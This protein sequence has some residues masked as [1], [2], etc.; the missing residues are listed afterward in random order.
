MERVDPTTAGLSPER[1]KMMDAAMQA[2]VD[3]GQLAGV[4]TVLVRHGKVAHW[5]M[6]GQRDLRQG[7]PVEEDTL[8]RI[9]SMTKPVTS[10]AVLMLLEEGCLQL[11]TPIAEYIPELKHMNVLIGQNDGVLELESLQ[12]PITIFDLLTHTSGLGYGLDASS[13]VEAMCQQAAVLRMDEKLVDK[14]RRVAEL[15]L[16]HQ[17]GERYTYS[18]GTDIL[19]YLV[20]II[21]GMPL[22]WFFQRRIF[23][24][25][26]MHDTDFY[27]PPEKM[28]R[29]AALYTTGLDGKLLDL[30]D[31]PGD[32]TQFPFGQW[33]DK[34]Q[35]PAF[36]SGG[37]GL[38]S[39]ATDYLRF[40]LMLRNK[41][42]LD[43]ERLVKPETV[44]LMTAPHLSSEK[45]NIPGAAYGLGVMV[46][47]DPARAQIP[48]SPGAYGAGG[49]AHTD[50]W[51]DPAQDLLGLLMTQ[52][53]H[54]AGLMIPFEFKILAEGT[55]ED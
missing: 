24:P 31:Y 37:G 6:H 36:L 27:V 17:P 5:A 41:G 40:G 10:L 18:I 16:H 32:P 8:F 55:V 47:T 54:Y 39:T 1:L 15:P 13:P 46:L 30:A 2:Y 50:F 25:L 51:Y 38:V 14:M 20:E 44:E 19:G 12:R 35:K 21:S 7:K 42:E 28:E 22:D 48:G 9:F 4:M 34:S 23:E 26:G 45:L 3:R 53:I 29:L 49:A 52:Y 43:G 33:T 11:N